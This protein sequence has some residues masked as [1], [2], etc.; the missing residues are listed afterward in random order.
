M[1]LFLKDVLTILA[2]VSKKF[3]E[4]GS[5][6]A[7]VSLTIKSTMRALELLSTKD[8]PFLQKLG[9]FEKC[10][11]PTFGSNIRRTYKL[12]GSDGQISSCREKLINLLCE[13]LKTRF[14]DNIAKIVSATSIA[15]FKQWPLNEKALEDFGDD[16]IKDLIDHYK[17]L[18]DNADEGRAEWPVLKMGIMEI[19]S[20]NLTV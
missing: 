12:L 19:F 18:L 1:S 6:V 17:N 10:E 7:D 14:E 16:M 15:N 4:E 13:K 5:V 3:Q 8:G 11:Y 2:R 20:K 9:E